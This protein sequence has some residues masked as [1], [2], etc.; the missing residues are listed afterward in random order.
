[1]A[2]QFVTIDYIVFAL[3]AVLILGVAMYMSREKKGH[4]KNSSDYFLASKALPW[5]AIGTSLIASNISAEQFIGMS[6]SGYA[7]GLAIASYEWM[8]AAALLII[9]KYFMPI[10]LEKKIY[11]MPQFLER[12]Y[13]NRVRTV[14]A[15]LWL[16][17]YV[18]V[19]LT[20]VLYL[21]ALALNT[22]MSVPFIY[23][24]IGLAL[25][26]ALYSIY[27]GLKSVAWTDFI[28]VAF[29]IGGGLITTYVA[30]N[31]V[32]DMY[33]GSGPVAGL[34][35][36]FNQFPEKFDM[37][38][39]KGQIMIP[40]GEGG[41]RDAFQDIPGISVLVGGL[42]VANF[43]YWGFNQYIIQKGLAA[44]NIKEAQR[45]LAFAGYLKILVP[46]IVVVPGIA[47]YALSD[48]A[49]SPSDKA[50]PYVL[51]LVPVGVR[52]I[53]FAALIA[54][55]V[56]S[57]AAMLNATANIFTIDVYKHF[58]NK[59]VSETNMVLV[60]RITSFTALLIAF[61]VARPLLGQLDQAFQYIQDFT[62]YITPGVVVIFIAGLLWKKGT[63]NAALWTA[64]L[65]IPLSWVFTAL[66][67]IPFMNRIG[68]VALI[69]AG[70]FITISRL[71][72]K[73]DH[74]KAVHIYKGLFHTG[75]VFN[76]MAIG[77]MAILAVLYI[78]LW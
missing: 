52:G 35:E 66:T 51:Q 56:S 37:I 55:V 10:F 5:W 31:A 23:G 3:Y 1:M 64:I 54:A 11:T 45:G 62:G 24:I 17:V 69:L 36:I 38:I 44:K 2:Q 8:S 48:G 50:Y 47:A 40:D 6:G 68:I 21:G 65:T 34:V 76:I 73:E 18:F 57:L 19:N 63:A 78:F 16:L 15:V 71:E 29:L 58:I 13:D 70:V 39:E 59:N 26:A 28:Q 33:G 7:I 77:I 32:A 74:P 43:A 46:L 30:L 12:R 61:L 20:S 72:T 49:L 9:A 4:V 27:G 67:D 41:T 22:I 25:F 42:W 60:G 75:T 14:M 53:A